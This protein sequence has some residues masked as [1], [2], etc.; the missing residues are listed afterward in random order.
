MG[1]QARI[2]SAPGQVPV[3]V[4]YGKTMKGH[5]I[6]FPSSF[7]VSSHIDGRRLYLDTPWIPSLNALDVSAALAISLKRPILV[8]L[9]IRI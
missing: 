3:I 8:Q 6:T 2:G 7:K 1:S 4:L 9:Q 5:Y